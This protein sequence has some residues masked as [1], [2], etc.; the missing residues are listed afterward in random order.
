MSD[1]NQAIDYVLKDEGGFVNNPLDPGGATNFGITLK[2]LQ[3]ARAPQEV[4]IDEVEKLTL[5]EAKSIYE[6]FYWSPAK[7]EDIIFQPIATALLDLCVNIGQFDTIKMAQ[8]AAG[9]TA[10]GMMGP[11]TITALNNISP[12]FPGAQNSVDFFLK[13]VTE[14]LKFRVERVK[15]NNALLEFLEGWINRDMRLLSLIR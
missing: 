3:R 6:R 15:C 5:D 10:D 1:F 13:L 2:T 7:I 11:L 9:I 8:I 4:S 12:M 14:V